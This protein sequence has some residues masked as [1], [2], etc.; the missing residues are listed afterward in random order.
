MEEAKTGMRGG[1]CEGNERGYWSYSL[2]VTIAW[3]LVD[4]LMVND[5]IGAEKRTRM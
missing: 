1:E 5:N 2:R 4:I 3:D